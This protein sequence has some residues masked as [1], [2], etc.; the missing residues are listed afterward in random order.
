M[1]PVLV[2]GC[3]A[4]E[5]LG[6]RDRI[7]HEN[8]EAALTAFGPIDSRRLDDVG[9]DRSMPAMTRTGLARIG[10]DEQV[11]AV[12]RCAHLA[13]ADCL[14]CT[15]LAGHLD[16]EG[17]QDRERSHVEAINGWIWSCL[18][19]RR[20]VVLGRRAWQAAQLLPFSDRRY[21]AMPPLRWIRQDDFLDPQKLLIINHEEDG[22]AAAELQAALAG[23][24]RIEVIDRCETSADR[25]IDFVH[26][27]AAYH[28]HVGGHTMAAD[29]PR[30]VE[31]WV[32]RIPVLRYRSR[33]SIP[34]RSPRG[35]VL[36]VHHGSNGFHCGSPGE[37]L[38]TYDDLRSDRVL[39]GKII[40]AGLKSVAPLVAGWRAVAGDLLS[41]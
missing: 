7:L 22:A 16:L 18:N 11:L 13:L 25:P 41:G 8:V 15:L 39:R 14:K 19:T 23:Y 35:E 2:F 28:V 1:T 30:L 12:G 33:R 40:D 17:D 24:A 36:D 3:A 37:V 29:E 5:K 32:N 21:H 9:P 6:T 4:E 20:A 31:G 34:V 38:A 27:D 26:L 10:V